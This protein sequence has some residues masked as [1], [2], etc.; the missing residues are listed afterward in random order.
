MLI[1]KKNNI[2][3]IYLINILIC[4]SPLSLILGNLIININLTLICFLGLLVYRQKIFLI[5][6][7]TYQFLIFF[8]FIYLVLITIINNWSLTL[9]NDLYKIHLYKSFF[10]FRFLILFFVVTKLIEDNNF[11]T[12]KFFF[13]CAI[14]SLII[15][16]DVVY[17]YIFGKNIFGYPTFKS[18]RA[19]SFFREE[20]VTGGY[21]QKFS[22]FLIFLIG[23]K[24]HK[25]RLNFVIILSFLVCTI[26]IIFTLNR[27]PLVI[28]LASLILYFLIE[29]KFKKIIISCLTLIILFFLIINFSS[30][31]R[32][33]TELQK[34]Y[35]E[36]KDIVINAPNLF[37]NNKKLQKTYF[38]SGYIIHFNSGIQVWKNNKFFGQGLKSFRLKCTFNENEICNTHPHNYFIEILVE[39]GLF[40]LLTIYLIFIVGLINFLKYYFNERNINSKLT[41]V[42]FFLLMFFEF[43]PFRSTGSFFTTSNSFFIFLILPI[44]LNIQKLEKYT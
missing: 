10:Y 33:K 3:L 44:F 32:V 39:T 36:S 24:I 29:K 17:Q 41:S 11:D 37:K 27:M 30:T 38:E 35:F 18:G 40:G 16:F 26:P 42:V 23:I 5:K 21:L 22:L 34:F 20:L 43:F 12:K 1:E 28:F 7:K 8:F 6:N 2:N 4:F 13:T 31:S 14:F 15:S 19:T 9:T 25:K